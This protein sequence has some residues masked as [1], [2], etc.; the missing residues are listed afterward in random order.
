MVDR[1]SKLNNYT[2]TYKSNSVNILEYLSRNP[3]Y[4]KSR[5]KQTKK[6]KNKKEEKALF[7]VCPFKVIC[8]NIP[9]DIYNN[10]TNTTQRGR[11]YNTRSFL[12]AALR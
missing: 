4:F 2:S 12:L 10:I 11:I 1:E 7:I 6:K 9:A 5:N 8:N 3:L